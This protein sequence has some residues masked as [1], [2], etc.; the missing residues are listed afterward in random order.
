MAGDHRALHRGPSR[1]PG[2]QLVPPPAADVGP[3]DRT[4]AG[5]PGLLRKLL[6]RLPPGR[7]PAVPSR[8]RR[9]RRRR[10]PPLRRRQAAAQCPVRPPHDAVRGALAFGSLRGAGSA[11][12]RSLRGA[13]RRTTARSRIPSPESRTSIRSAG[14]D[15]RAGLLD[16]TATI[17]T[18][19]G[20]AERLRERGYELRGHRLVRSRPGDTSRDSD[21]GSHES[22]G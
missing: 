11:R 9:R 6:E 3:P 5:H 8:R 17:G 1:R 22:H 14:Q 15:E 4:P 21:H 16:D 7:R 19:A 12:W 18:R 10:R 2:P 13:G 20:W